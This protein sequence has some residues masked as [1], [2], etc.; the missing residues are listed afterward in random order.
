MKTEERTSTVAVPAPRK[1]AVGAGV[2]IERHK[3]AAWSS[4]ALH[5]LIR[6]FSSLRLTIVCLGL[7][8]ILVFVG[9]LAQVN[10][11]LYKSQNEFFRSFFIYWGPAGATWKIPIFPGGY[12]VGANW[13]KINGKKGDEARDADRRAHDRPASARDVQT[14]TT[15]D[16]NNDGTPDYVLKLIENKPAKNSDEVNDRARA[17]IVLLQGADGKLSRA[18]IA[19]KLLQCTGCGG[20]FYGVVDA[21]ANVKIENNVIVVEQDHGSREVSDVT[22]RFRYEATSKRFMLIGFDYTEHDRATAKVSLESTNYLTGVR[23]TN[24]RTSKITKTRI[25]LDDIDYE[26]LEEDAVKRLGLG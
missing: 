26:K 21:P 6:F 4:H 12:L 19:D 17:L 7:G 15:A 1:Q 20:A 11:G 24:G 3:P 23:K 10:L 18:A 9:T 2:E 8:L 14:A 25:F 22:F 5:K 16:L 13:D